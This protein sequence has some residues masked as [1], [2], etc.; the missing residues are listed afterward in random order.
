MYALCSFPLK[1]LQP[2]H[3]TASVISIDRLL[4]TVSA[5]AK[6]R[7]DTNTFNSF[8]YSLLGRSSSIIWWID[9]WLALFFG[10]AFIIEIHLLNIQWTE[11]TPLTNRHPR[12]PGSYGGLPRPASKIS[13]A[14]MHYGSV[15]IRN[16]QAV[17]GTVTVL[18]KVMLVLCKKNFKNCHLLASEQTGL[19]ISSRNKG[20]PWSTHQAMLC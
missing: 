20:K 7:A 6:D 10:V 14:V 13:L 4:H 2:R 17:D 1:S 5:T 11:M 9:I 15:V 8:I 3:L 18:I 19:I 12:F 16:T